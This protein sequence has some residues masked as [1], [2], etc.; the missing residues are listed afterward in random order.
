MK[1]KRWLYFV[2]AFALF[3]TIIGPPLQNEIKAEDSI[4]VH[5][6]KIEQ[7]AFSDKFSVES[8]NKATYTD[9]KLPQGNESNS[10]SSCDYQ[11]DNDPMDCYY[12]SYHKKD[13]RG[14]KI[15]VIYPSG[16]TPSGDFNNH[17]ITTD[18]ITATYN[19]VGKYT[20][21]NNQKHQMGAVL[22]IQ[23]KETKTNRKI[24]NRQAYV[25]IPNNLYS[26]LHYHQISILNIN[27]QFTDESG[28]PLK[29]VK[30]NE[31]NFDV[32]TFGSL[33]GGEHLET[34]K[35]KW[36]AE[37][38]DNL[39]KLEYKLSEST[40]VDRFEVGGIEE[41]RGIGFGRHEGNK[42]QTNP[43]GKDY[44]FN[45]WLG[46]ENFE[47][48]G[49]SFKLKENETSY[50]FNFLSVIGYT[51]QTISSGRIDALELDNP[52]KTVTKQEEPD[53]NIE[54][55]HDELN[56]LI[57]G[58][59]D[60]TIND[61]NNFNYFVYQKTY[62][63]PDS[64]IAKPKP[65]LLK[66]KLPQ[67]ITLQTKTKNDIVLYNT[68]GQVI[69]ADS[70]TKLNFNQDINEF[71]YE[72]SS[73][74]IQEL[75]FNGKEFAFKIKVK[76]LAD[77]PIK[78]LNVAYIK[79]GE[80]EKPTN[81]VETQ[82]KKTKLSISKNVVTK[83]DEK[84]QVFTIYLD[85][86]N[87]DSP[88]KNK[89]YDLED[90]QGKIS[91]IT[92]EQNNGLRAVLKIKHNQSYTI[93]GLE[94][95]E[96]IKITE[97]AHPDFDIFYKTSNDWIAQT[98]DDFAKATISLENE[99]NID[100]ENRSNI[101]LADLIVKKQVE[102]IDIDQN[103]EFGF[104]LKVKDISKL[105]DHQYLVMDGSVQ[106][107]ILGFE[108]D[109]ISNEIKI[110]HNQVLTIKELPQNVEFEIFESPTQGYLRYYKINNNQEQPQL[111]GSSGLPSI[112]INQD[113]LNFTFINKQ[114]VGKLKLTKTVSNK[115][116]LY[117][118]N[119]EFGFDIVE[120]T[121]SIKGKYPATIT[122]QDATTSSVEVEFIKGIAKVSLKEGQT[123]T[124]DKLPTTNYYVKEAQ[125]H[126]Y[127]PEWS[128]TPVN[129]ENASTGT[130]HETS[131]G[132]LI[133]DDVIE[134]KF[135]NKAN[136]TALDLNITKK[137]IDLPAHLTNQEFNFT[138]KSQK[139]V[140]NGSYTL[141][142]K[143]LKDETNT[144]ITYI[145]FVD[146]VATFS[147][148]TDY[149]ATIQSL[150]FDQYIISEDIANLD[151]A[152]VETNNDCGSHSRSLAST[153]NPLNN[154]IEI[155]HDET[156]CKQIEFT[157]TFNKTG[158]IKI[159]KAIEGE[160]NQN[161]I[162]KFEI[163]A[164][165]NTK[166]KV[167]NNK[168][169]LIKQDG[170]TS[171]ITFDENGILNNYIELKP[172]Q[173][174]TIKG[175]PLD[176]TLSVKEIESS[177]YTIKWMVDN[178]GQYTTQDQ[179][180]LAQATITTADQTV[181]FNFLNIKN[182]VV[183]P[184]KGQLQVLKKANHNIINDQEFD[185]TLK[186]IGNYVHDNQ[187]LPKVTIQDSQGNIVQAEKD[188]EFIDGKYAF[189]LQKDQK[190][191]FTNLNLENKYQVNEKDYSAQ[192]INTTH[193]FLGNEGTHTT[194]EFDL[195]ECGPVI[196]TY[197]NTKADQPPLEPKT[198]QL[199]IEKFVNA[200][201][202]K[203]QDFK[204]QL[205][206]SE[207]TKDLV[208]NKTYEVETNSQNIKNIHFNEH[209]LAQMILSHNE[210]VYIKG[211]P[212]TLQLT[213]KEINS[214]NIFDV[215]YLIDSSKE[216]HQQTDSNFAQVTIKDATTINIDYYNQRVQPPTPKVGNLKLRKIVNS[217]QV[218][219]DLFKFAISG[220]KN[221]LANK[222]YQVD[223]N[224]TL[225]DI[226][227]DSEG[228]TS[229]ELKDGQFI[230]IK[231]LEDQLELVIKEILTDDQNYQIKYQVNNDDYQNQDEQNFVNI[232]IQDQQTN[233]VMY[234]NTLLVP[235]VENGKLAI[236]KFVSGPNLTKEDFE[237]IVT[238][239]D[240]SNF[241][242]EVK[243]I[244]FNQDGKASDVNLQFKNG[245][246]TLT[247]KHQE[248]ILITGLDYATYLVKEFKKDNLN[249]TTKH[250][251]NGTSKVSQTTDDFKISKDQGQNIIYY[252]DEII[253]EVANGKILVTKY[254]TG[255]RLSN[256]S[257]DFELNSSN[258]NYNQIV[259]VVYYDA[260]GKI[261]ES[262]K[263]LEFKNGSA[264]FSLKDKE[265]LLIKGL[266]KATY[267]V[268]ET[269]QASN[270]LEGMQIT[271]SL[272]GAENKSD[273]TN[274]FNIDNEN[275]ANI[276]FNNHL[277]DL[278]LPPKGE[279]TIS[280]YA[281]GDKYNNQ[282]FNFEITNVTNPQ[283]QASVS[284]NKYNKDGKK[285][286]IT[287]NFVDGKASLTLLDKER[288][289]IKG[290]AYA[291][292]HVQ[293]IKLDQ[294]NDLIKVDHSVDGQNNTGA[295]TNDFAITED[296]GQNIIYYNSFDNIPPPLIKDGQIV[297][298]K[299]ASGNLIIDQEFKFE[300]TNT[301]NTNYQDQIELIKVDQN[302][303]ATKSQV[304][305]VDS[306]LQVSLY[307]Q[308]RVY[309]KGLEKASYSIK[310][311][312]TFDDTIITNVV[313]DGIKNSSATT[314]DLIINDDTKAYNVLYHNKGQDK[315]ID[316]GKIL[317]TKYATG[318]RLT[319]QEFDFEVT[320]SN[321]NYNATVKFYHYNAK[322][323]VINEEQSITFKAGKINF[324]LKDKER[325][326]IKGLEKASY[327]VKETTQASDKLD[328]MQIS[329]TLNGQEYNASVTN[330]FKIDNETSANIIFNNHLAD[331]I[332]PQNGRL[333]LAKYATGDTLENESFNFEIKVDKENLNQEIDA[334]KYDQ[335]NQT[336]AYK[337]EF[338]DSVA[339]VSLKDKERLVIEN[340]PY[341][342]YQINE[343]DIKT[344]EN[345]IS[346]QHLIDGKTIQGEKTQPLEINEKQNQSVVYYNQGKVTPP[347]ENVKG[348]IIISK[349]AT[350]DNLV[351]ETFKF[352][353]TNESDKTYAKTIKGSLYHQNGEK[354]A[355]T[356]EFKDSK[357][358][359]ELKDKDRLVLKG[360]DY[361]TFSLKEHTLANKEFSIS[362]TLNGK[363]QNSA[364]TQQF[365]VEKDQE[366]N[367]VFYNQGVDNIL[368]DGKLILAKYAT[369]DTLLN[370]D[371]N[372]KITKDTTDYNQSVSA[373]VYNH[374][375]N[376]IE[377]KTL[378]FK[379]G[380][381]NLTLKDKQRIEIEG[382]KYAQYNIEETSTYQG[383]VVSHTINGQAG[384]NQQTNIANISISQD[385]KLNHVVFYNKG[386]DNPPLPDGRIVLSKHATGQTLENKEF[387]FELIHQ[388]ATYASSVDVKI[389]DI[390]GQESIV[391]NNKFIAGKLSI[392][393]KDKE[394][395]IV[396]G[397]ELG[398]YTIKE[399]SDYNELEVK[400]SINGTISN[401]KVTQEISIDQQ[402]K[403]YNVI[404]N[405]KGQDLIKDEGKLIITKFALGS[406]LKDQSFDFEITSDNT[407]YT[408]DLKA[409][410]INEK[411]KKI[412]YTLK[413]NQ[414]KATFTLKDK[415]KLYVDQ[416]VK[417]NY[418]IKELV[419]NQEIIVTHTLNG[420]ESDQSTTEKFSIDNQ[421]S[422]NIVFENYLAD[423]PIKD[424]GK[425][426]ITKYAT[427]DLIDQ[428][429]F[430]F[431][432][433]KKDDSNYQES[434]KAY[435]F[436]QDGSKKQIILDFKNG[437]ANFK[438]KHNQR[439]EIEGLAYAT[440]IVKEINLD[441]MVGFVSVQH[442]LNG[443]LNNNATSDDITI[444]KDTSANVVYFNKGDNTPPLVKDGQ[445]RLQKFIS[446][447]TI[448]DNVFKFII[449][450]EDQDFE[451]EVTLTKID[452]K[453][454]ENTITTQF[455]QGQLSINLKHKERFIING[456][457]DGKY[458]IIEDSNLNN[459]TTKHYL[460]GQENNSKESDYFEIKENNKHYSLVYHNDEQIVPPPVIENGQLELK[461][462]VS[463]KLTQDDTYQFIIENT[464]LV[465]D[466][467]QVKIKHYPLKGSPTTTSQ[468]F[469][470]GQLTINLKA[471]ERVLI[472]ELDYAKYIVKEITQNL[473]TKIEVTHTIDGIE[474]SGG[475]TTTLIEVNEDD[476]P[477]VIFNNH[478]DH[479]IIP[480]IA[481]LRLEKY[482]TSYQH[483]DK[484]QEFTFEIT[485]LSDVGDQ[486]F[487][488]ISN[489]ENNPKLLSFNQTTKTMKLK[490]KAY[491]YALIQGLPNHSE[492]QIKEL[493]PTNNDYLA[494]YS[495]DD[496]K[497]IQ[498]S[499]ADYPIVKVNK[500][501]N[502]RVVYD[503]LFKKKINNSIT[504]TKKATGDFSLD[505]K[506]KF[507]IQNKTNPTYNAT[508]Q[509]IVY[510]N[511]QEVSKKDVV[512]TNGKAN[513]E[514]S[515][516]QS[517][518]ISNLEQG[519]YSITEDTSAYLEGDIATTWYVGKDS[520]SKTTTT[521]D[522][523]VKESCNIDVL[524]L[525]ELPEKIPPVLLIEQTG[526]LSLSKL[527]SSNQTD[528]LDQLFEFK[529]SVKD[530]NQIEEVKNQEYQVIDSLN[531]IKKISFDDQGVVNETI[532]LKHNQKLT[533]KDL[534]NHLVVDIHEVLSANQ[535]FETK[536][537]ID[538]QDFVKQSATQNAQAKINQNGVDVTYLN[539]AKT[540]PKYALKVAKK[541]TGPVDLNS[542]FKFE[543]NNLD[544]QAY[545]TTVM[546]NILNT[547][548]LDNTYQELNFVNGH[549]ILTLKANE[550]ATIHNLESA[551]Y[552][553]NEQDPNND[554]MST[555]NSIDNKNEKIG[556]SSE[557][558]Y[559]NSENQPTFI[560]TNIL[561][562]EPT[563]VEKP[564]DPPNCLEN[565]CQNNNT[566]TNGNNQNQNSQNVIINNNNK[567]TKQSTPLTGSKELSI[568]IAL[569]LVSACVAL[570]IHRYNKGLF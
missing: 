568:F 260:K 238:K 530:V 274:N 71:T 563:I 137:S 148:L 268:K 59:E 185:F 30:N 392:T 158:N 95:N 7:D 432:I 281:T 375:G 442:Y 105:K 122:N 434:I 79:A 533:I 412:D 512:F 351:D 518:V 391:Q 548:S 287:L 177:D 322:G 206:A 312:T 490:L 570:L 481:N 381:L 275:A 464:D 289:E 382:L 253:E 321:P 130:S 505:E 376:L 290:L 404:F 534:P 39:D 320:S 433:S 209:G 413:F 302:G 428:N 374:L 325:I 519:T 436:N 192:A 486:T 168:Y 522:L 94:T 153:T 131:E 394:Q 183:P 271:H 143:D 334:I 165:E 224:T 154:V 415:E 129:P 173:I 20:D 93:H 561:E 251:L 9:I 179:N 128:I 111:D 31:N 70:E 5:G 222:T 121:K 170:T 448:N 474:Q 97:Q 349:Y 142:L 156:S 74:Q 465:N 191:I 17:K 515:D 229:I 66:D 564:I 427:G 18:I 482:V 420:L 162:F 373:K 417:A 77:A 193:Y 219:T 343:L 187:N 98:Q 389:I 149:E 180:N 543:I 211:L 182:V 234:L 336:S 493:L 303:K 429:E 347:I 536:Y 537:S 13:G 47:K 455:K 263:T 12:F 431:M 150:P 366:N 167:A 327:V 115:H 466:N 556:L 202:D 409:S 502:I 2:M 110:K 124:I 491:Q 33:N 313:N 315:I 507:S 295:L 524:Y 282:Q 237:F 53:L 140:L 73:K 48:S 314:K 309:L 390:N 535:D 473:D 220:D 329:H 210:Y 166:E 528:D 306:K 393:L 459:V 416:L 199:R 62:D 521:K 41:F 60:V 15:A 259:E 549:A 439:L 218:S 257:F 144:K 445:I 430:D 163:K 227:F 498:Q 27:I 494:S 178:S 396:S 239:K 255:N 542:E 112:I 63:I 189:K 280:K 523:E 228:K 311:I 423:L 81:E 558:V 559:L 147:M 386:L 440:Y 405:N 460:N 379:D 354:E 308:E 446:G 78:H 410:I 246:T 449:E 318:S 539:I 201:G 161:K 545:S 453:G 134:V 175:L 508:I 160:I 164:T 476:K 176:V 418:L 190:A 377:T 437:S 567:P 544:N 188:F 72:L 340:L 444:T 279:L 76:K 479:D 553:V 395:A 50:D 285:T 380:V 159:A 141:L 350:G 337:V 560:S 171:Q 331:L 370:K 422:A 378:E 216:Y 25:D 197:N 541:I 99:I 248:R 226:T 37:G 44:E 215:K 365:K 84:Q 225:K 385:H 452:A 244:H 96:Q 344:N 270:E 101:L 29:L 408:K 527:V 119:T 109:G 406:R 371:F 361:D 35:T 547:L 198:G 278:P 262:K 338:K 569:L 6:I 174:A 411:G 277:D 8:K 499:E 83:E 34:D 566:N 221:I 232:K 284:A 407:N 300:I 485:A 286:Q 353:L 517:I 345:L 513:F 342:T 136:V 89:E 16:W 194:S 75:N 362:H 82:I 214:D 330:D 200:S 113:Q 152:S 503:N 236:T 510:E 123:I 54:N 472:S 492:Y 426:L 483:I 208:A 14:K 87:Q 435:L 352:T 46:S 68:N 509:A 88:A 555:K 293:E 11:K 269:T 438:L 252:N 117:D 272:N 456:L 155:R 333:I 107:D 546:V 360:L 120:K 425:I 28:T 506:F 399:T 297:L 421:T 310:E 296:N 317:V 403:N 551:H 32:I 43:A 323:K 61:I 273:T 470:D 469:S 151:L 484:E 384:N 324:K 45:D 40:L 26:G 451:D 126:W 145:E 367:I 358:T 258:E 231:D 520:S 186:V 419:T 223:T 235:E 531:Q 514:L 157:N 118:P 339:K 264:T 552:Q 213:I 64:S 242:K 22:T 138:I 230:I 38:V 359:F 424:N 398:K 116:A 495:I 462:T 500:D 480:E 335:N 240:D 125:N 266:E 3:L 203:E 169:Q 565:N 550:F 457:A 294:L 52:S 132:T 92:F 357:A 85:L 4:P 67:G 172:G 243:A 265:K 247:L 348:K 372:F 497:F 49:V 24:S 212:D 356:L 529:L 364:T 496:S 443:T 100:F 326:L 299:I 23:P 291:T 307:H 402:S 104:R 516:N 332:P 19:N 355:I 1:K 458:K 21:T 146:G 388:D 65:L 504:V 207:N 181:I 414:G 463:G 304:N 10:N 127:S 471:N 450:S 454:L 42:D 102:A 133:N 387:T 69:A 488:I 267:V 400:H 256:Q 383:M 250:T 276:I 441:Q 501:K 525:N 80:Y 195:I 316:D 135:T 283:Y 233:E 86:L 51:W 557:K 288:V 90:Q 468:N 217:N 540:M 346:V 363:K 139:T 532:K 397:L 489:N 401:G 562:V 487:N 103:K 245:S 319:N 114:E 254:A 447:Q 261:D 57:Q 91:K 341:A 305:F 478:L 538:N 55:K 58:Q 526:D 467:Q 368:D 511:N 196:I 328:G 298:S 249:Y 106:H 184:K 554:K 204:F 292:Y 108:P 241:N 301:T 475:D 56:D 461:K 477:Y 205:L 36:R 369:G